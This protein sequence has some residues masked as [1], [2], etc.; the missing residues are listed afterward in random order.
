MQCY[1]HMCPLAAANLAV[2]VQFRQTFAKAN[3]RLKNPG[4]YVLVAHQVHKELGD[5]LINH[6]P[7]IDINLR[8]Y[9]QQ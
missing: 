7:K 3:E 9:P 4:S 5:W 6:I 8:K 2:H 1:R